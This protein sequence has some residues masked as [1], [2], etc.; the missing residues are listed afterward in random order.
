MFDCLVFIEGWWIMV[1]L[2]GCEIVTITKYYLRDCTEQWGRHKWNPLPLRRPHYTFVTVFI[3]NT[4]NHMYMQASM[5]P[6]SLWLF[7]EVETFSHFQVW[8]YSFNCIASRSSTLQLVME[9]KIYLSHLMLTYSIAQ[10]TVG[11]SPIFSGGLPWSIHY[12]SLLSG[13]ITKLKLSH[14]NGQLTSQ[15]NIEL[16]TCYTTSFIA[17]TIPPVPQHAHTVLVSTREGPQ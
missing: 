14:N 8:L 10:G 2:T 11:G 4:K 16:A 17:S 3:G 9:S 12:H 7:T 13:S 15:I 5:V 6:K 1:L